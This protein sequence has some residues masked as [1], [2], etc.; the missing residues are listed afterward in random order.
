MPDARFDFAF[1]IRIADAARQGDDAVMREHVA[2]ERIQ[3]GV[4]DVG[5]EHAFVQIVEDDHTDRAA[6]STKRALVELGPRLRTR[7]QDEQADRF[8]AVAER[9]HEEPRASVLAGLRV[10][11]HRPVAVIDLTFF[12]GRGGDDDV[13]VGRRRSRRAATKRRTLA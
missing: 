2:I 12:A 1:A 11:D 3:G 9:E 10:P 4:V 13:R 7:P 8:A 5:R 6:Q